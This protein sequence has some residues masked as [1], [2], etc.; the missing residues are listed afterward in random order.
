MKFKT[1]F[2]D[3]DGVINSLIVSKNE[4]PRSP[5]YTHEV[6]FL[7][8]TSAA[9]TRAKDKGYEIY[10]VTNQPDIE[11]G[12]LS[13]KDSEEINLKIMSTFPQI[14]DVYVC[15][16]T[17]YSN[18]ICRKPKPGLI[19]NSRIYPAIDFNNGWMVG[20]R[21]VDV[22]AGISANLKTILIENEHSWT[23]TTT[24]VPI[25]GLK[26]QY[27]VTNLNEAVEII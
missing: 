14:N 18:C 25:A 8:G 23:T 19:V 1:L 12:L 13:K 16:H 17:Q 11:K 27:K 26:P 2:L 22:A 15:P 7:P 20:D 3:R 9:L 24:G 5:R 21:W 6:S 10:V 4:P